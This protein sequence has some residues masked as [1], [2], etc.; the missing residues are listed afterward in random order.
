MLGYEKKNKNKNPN[1]FNKRNKIKNLKGNSYGKTIKYR[2][3]F[4]IMKATMQKK[5]II[6]LF[7]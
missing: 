2:L 5:A 7:Q 3:M 4:E 6:A 1:I